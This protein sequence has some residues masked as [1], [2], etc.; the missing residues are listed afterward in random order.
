MRLLNPPEADKIGFVLHILLI[1]TENTEATENL[2]LDTDSHRW[3]PFLGRQ[4]FFDKAFS[5]SELL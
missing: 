2:F 1:A 5:R 4:A 3:T